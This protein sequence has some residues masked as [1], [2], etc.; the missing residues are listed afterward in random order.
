MCLG[1]WKLVA[2][3]LGSINAGKPEA[4]VHSYQKEE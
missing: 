2:F 3:L 1:R 4:N